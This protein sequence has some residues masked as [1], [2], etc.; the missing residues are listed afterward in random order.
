MSSPGS[1]EASTASRPD[2]GPTPVVDNRNGH[3]LT[4]EEQLA[5]VQQLRRQLTAKYRPDVMSQPS[6]IR[7]MARMVKEVESLALKQGVS[8]EVLA[9][10]VVNRTIGDVNVRLIT[11]KI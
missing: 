1:P 3:G 10:E 4:E 7:L 11:E 8:R 5:L 2:T 9:R 6:P